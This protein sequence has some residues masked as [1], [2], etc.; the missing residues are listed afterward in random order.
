MSQANATTLIEKCLTDE[1]L[2]S[3]L[4][5]A[6]ASGFE[7]IVMELGLACSI[8]EFDSALQQPVPLSGELSGDLSDDQLDG[9]AGGKIAQSDTPD[10][11]LS[12]LTALK[13]TRG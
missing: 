3:R 1:A 2:R 8:E 10:N 4:E 5:S 7:Q 11:M 13:A 9:V 12:L 6:G